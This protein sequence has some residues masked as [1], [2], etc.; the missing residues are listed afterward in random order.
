MVILVSTNSLWLES[1]WFRLVLWLGFFFPFSFYDTIVHS[2][3]Q[4]HAKMIKSKELVYREM[5]KHGCTLW[6]RLYRDKNTTWFLAFPVFIFGARGT[7]AILQSVYTLQSGFQKKSRYLLTSIQ[8]LTYPAGLNF[9]LLSL[10]FK[11][12]K[13]GLLCAVFNQV[14]QKTIT[15]IVHLR[16]PIFFSILVVEKPCPGKMDAFIVQIWWHQDYGCWQVSAGLWEQSP[17]GFLFYGVSVLR[18]VCLIIVEMPGAGDLGMFG[19]R[20]SARRSS[21]SFQNMRCAA[22]AWDC[23]V[24]SDW[25]GLGCSYILRQPLSFPSIHPSSWEAPSVVEA[26]GAR[27]FPGEPG[28]DG[29]VAGTRRGGG[30]RSL[31]A[32]L[33]LRSSGSGRFCGAQCPR[34]WERG[35]EGKCPPRL[36][37]RD[38]SVQRRASLV[39]AGHSRGYASQRTKMQLKFPP[40]GSLLTAT[41]ERFNI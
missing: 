38:H 25:Q 1:M 15:D 14:Q 11:E 7:W 9:R 19:I 33:L 36:V 16:K 37:A 34:W 8:D 12:E 22:E 20:E 35:E 31:S 2:H 30:L 5:A 24:S 10:S 3:P 4:L 13:M 27:P 29:A 21:C 18:T 41:T 6:C 28:C 17:Y 39:C 32:L 23:W 26:R 40:R